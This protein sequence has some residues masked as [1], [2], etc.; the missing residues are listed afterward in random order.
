MGHDLYEESTHAHRLFDEADQQLGF[1]LSKL[2]FEGPEELLTRTVHAQIAIFVT[3]L[4]IDR[5]LRAR[6]PETEPQLA[7]GLSLGEF[8][9]LVC[10]RSISL[11]DGLGLVRRRGELMEEACKNLPG[12]MASILG[13]PFDEVQSICR[14]TGVE[15]ANF[16]SREQIVISGPVDAVENACT[17]AKEKNAKRAFRLNVGGAFHSSLMKE[18]QT[19]L[20]AALRAV[21]INEPED[22]FIANVTGEAVSAPEEIRTLLARQLTHPV[23]WVKTM[24]TVR[25]LGI[26]ELLEVGPGRVLKGLAKKIDSAFHVTSVGTIQ[27]LD[28]FTD[29]RRHTCS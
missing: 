6:S 15:I 22:T 19:G 9:A 10:L 21:E 8:T 20:E 18:A 4:A 7:C 26:T 27:A 5:A 1:S 29:A 14:E 28:A 11:A 17:L 12:T 24:E 13:L 25:R 16:N 23:Q 3:S 2:C